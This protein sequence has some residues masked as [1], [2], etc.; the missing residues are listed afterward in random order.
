MT[1]ET[2]TFGLEIVALRIT[3]EMVEGLRYKLQMMGIPIEGPT[4][5]YCDNKLVVKN[6]TQPESPCKNRHNSVAYHKARE[7]TFMSKF[8]FVLD[9]QFE[10]NGKHFFQF[11]NSG[12]GA[13][14]QRMSGLCCW[15]KIM[16]EGNPALYFEIPDC[17]KILYKD[18][19]DG[20][21]PIEPGGL[22]LKE[23]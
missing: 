6:T 20:V 16:K 9:S 4:N 15:I 23:L 22:T 12:N 18:M 3:I 8:C 10:D 13:S 11:R 2:S 19:K 14:D 1:I 7:C 5:I 17:K 21:V